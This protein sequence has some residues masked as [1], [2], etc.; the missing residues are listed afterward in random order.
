ME[1][2]LLRLGETCWRIEDAQRLAFLIDNQAYY[3]ALYDA[4]TR[5][6]R[7]IWILGWAFDPRTRLAPDGREGP[8]DPDEIGQILLRLTRANP[9][10]DVRVLIWRSALSINGGHPFLE[11]RAR[12]LFAGSGIHYREDGETP[13]GACHHQKLVLVDGEV[14]FCGG[15][16]ITANRWDTD[17]HVD[18]DPRRILPH[19]SRHAPRHEVMMLVQGD[20]AAALSE[21]FGERWRRATGEALKGSRSTSEIWPQ[22]VSSDLTR[23]KVAI[24][25][26]EPPLKGRAGVNEVRRLA[27]ASIAAATS[28]IYL[29]NQYLTSKSVTRA[30]IERLR[31]PA[32]PEV[33]LIL[34]GR[35]PSWFDRITMDHARVPLLRRLFEADRYGRFRAFAPMTASG[36]PIIVH[37]KVSIFDDVI[38][39]I[40]SANLNSRSEGFDTECELAI[41]AS[42]QPS[43]RQIARLCDRLL[44]HFLGVAEAEF[45]QARAQGG[46]LIGAIERLNGQQRLA[47]IAPRSVGWWDAFVSRHRLGDPAAPEES[48]RLFK[49]RLDGRLEADDD[50]PR[51]DPAQGASR[52]AS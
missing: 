27:L 1:R 38:A 5:A 43:R 32:G 44:A 49:D 23:S 52:E 48:W 41:H 12:K 31:E 9:H 42:D 17:G 19:R 6:R 29:E 4:L 2:A 45:A 35:A 36:A 47:P 14:A 20:A 26:T 34:P 22:M 10:L 46:G 51:L 7:S 3:A 13:F 15:G 33:I 11:H 21:L 24:V 37:S 16:D 40:G 30:L 28:T 18:G 25:R 39:R 8:D 50:R